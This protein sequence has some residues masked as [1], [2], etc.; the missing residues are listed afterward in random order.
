MAH[1]NYATLGYI[2]GGRRRVLTRKNEQLLTAAAT[3]AGV[4][5]PLVLLPFGAAG[6]G[7]GLL[8]G[9]ALA[10]SCMRTVFASRNTRCHEAFERAARVM[11]QAALEKQRVHNRV[12]GRLDGIDITLAVIERK[13][14][15]YYRLTAKLPVDAPD[16]LWF[17]RQDEHERRPLLQAD[18]EVG[19]PAIDSAAYLGGDRIAILAALD[20]VTREA[21]AR[22]SR[23][24]P[25]FG[26]GTAAVRVPVTAGIEALE[27]A[28]R[29]FATVVCALNV[30]APTVMD[31][32]ARRATG[33]PETGV[34]HKAAL[35]F[36][37]TFPEH[38]ERLGDDE[39]TLLPVLLSE[40]TK[41]VE[42]AA[43][44]LADVGT[45]GAVAP[46]RRVPES[47]MKYAAFEA[48][49]NAIAAI[50]ERHGGSVDGRLSLAAPSLHDGA[51]SMAEEEGRLSLEA[52]PL[53]EADD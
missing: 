27:T 9:G 45:M 40:D 3:G 7:L 38:L 14:G 2:L 48:A 36:A 11:D 10:F 50:E 49:Q 46:L 29:D 52:P 17:T 42:A 12:R 30:P 16:G 41:A 28:V 1:A 24:E 44:V 35:A 4:L 23:H 25:I 5:L 13:T 21:M 8:L 6:A 18:F 33:D 19:D 32:L 39:A 47:V 26:R 20:P 37:E 51:L 15:E 53:V 34:R 22:L 31:R 43:A